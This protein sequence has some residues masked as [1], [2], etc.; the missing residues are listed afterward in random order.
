MY[1]ASDIKK[2][3]AQINKLWLLS[4]SSIVGKVDHPLCPDD[5]NIYVFLALIK[6]TLLALATT[7]LGSFAL[8]FELFFSNHKIKKKGFLIYS[9][10]M[11][12]YIMKMF[13]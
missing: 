6:Q 5:V 12:I 8:F 1:T 4:Y 9:F 10:H 13:L 11:C 3:E 2:E 7:V